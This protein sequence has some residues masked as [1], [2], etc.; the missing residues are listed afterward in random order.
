[1]LRRQG[2]ESRTRGDARQIVYVGDE[3]RA[4]AIGG[5]LSDAEIRCQ[6]SGSAALDQ[7]ETDDVDCVVAE[8]DLQ[9]VDGSQLLTAVAELSPDTARVLLAESVDDAPPNVAVVPTRPRAEL[10]ARAARRV[11][12]ATE[13]QSLR[14]EHDRIADR[15]ETLVEGSPD[16]ILTL[17]EDSEVV[18]ANEA[19]ERVFGYAPEAVVG[20]SVQKLLDESVHDCVSE[21]VESLSEDPGH[22]QRDYVELPGRHQE[23]HQVPLAV[24]FRETER[25]G[26]H[27]FSAVVRDVS[28]RERLENRLEAEKRKTKELHEVAVML[29]ECDSVEEVCRLAVETAEQLLEFDLCAVDTVKDGELVPQAVSKG[30]PTDGYYTTTPLSAEGNLA[31][32][33]YRKGESLRTGDLHDEGV[34][35]AASGYR[36]ALTVPIADL[37]VFQAVSKESGAFEESDRE[38]AE[39]LASHVAQ[40]LQRMRSEAALEAE[41]DRFAALFENI[42]EPTIDYGMHDGRPVVHSVNEAFEEVFGYDAGEAVGRTIGELIVPDEKQSEYEDHIDRMRGQDHLNT[43]VRRGGTDGI[44]DFLLRTAKI[45]DE[46][47]GGYAI[48]TDITDRKQLERDLTR[49]KQKIEELHHVAVN[50]EG[51]DTPD[52][53]YRRTV[54]AAEE[55]LKFDICGIDIEEDGY[56]VPK[57]ASS[58]LDETGYDVL[59]ADEGLAGETYQTGKSFVVDDV[60][61]VSDVE[62]VSNRYRSLLSVPFGDEGVLQAGAHTPDEFDREDRKLAELLVSHAAEALVRVQSEEAL[63]EERDRFAALFENTRD[64]V[65]YHDMCDGEPVIRSVNEAFEEVFGYDAESVLG[66]SLLDCIVPDDSIEEAKRHVEQMRQGEHVDA[67]VRRETETGTRDFLVRTASV[68]GDDTGGYVIYTDITDRKQLERDLGRANQKFEELH[69]VA[70]NLEGLN[71]AEEIYEET[72]EAA[73]EIL[74]FDICGVAIEED[75][76][77]VPRATTSDY[78]EENYEVLR[79]D[80]GIAG[81]TYQSGQS[82]VIEDLHRSPEA[83][84]VN[85]TVRSCLSVPVGEEGVLQAGSRTVDEFDQEDAKLAELLV[86][87]AS[88]ALQRLQSEAALREERD[89]FAALF[90]NVPEP[91]A[92]YELRDGDP[93][94]DSV[95]EAFEETFGYSET[96]AVGE[97]ID[98]LLVPDDRQAQAGRL[99]ERVDSG[100]R[101]DAEVKRVAD[102]GVRDFLLRNA[103]VSGD[104]GNYVIYTDVTERKQREE[105][106]DALHHATRDLMAAERQR[107]IC[108]TAVETARD[109]LDIPHSSVFK[110]D[111]ETERLEPYIVPDATIATMG[112]APSFG[113]GEGIVGSVFEDGEVAH[114]DNAWDDARALDDGSEGIRAFGAFPLGDWGVMTVASAS[115]GAFDGYEIDLVR[116]LAA[117]VEVALN[118]AA[119]EAELAEQRSQLAELDR[120]NAVIRDVD[121]LLVRS[122]T[123]EEIAQEV[124]DRLAKSDHYQFAWTGDTMAGSNKTEPTAWAGVEEGYLERIVEM[125]DETPTGPSQK[126]VETGTVQ[127]VQSVPDDE[128]F[129]PWR[130][131]A[132]KRGYQSA[133]A[134]PLRYR[135]T[136][137]GVLCVYA[138]RA[139]AFDDREQAV[140]AELGETIGHAINAAENKKALLSD[141][142]VEVEFEIREGEGFFARIP[143]EEGGTF[144]LEGVTMTAEGSFVTFMTVDGLDPDRVLELADDAPDVEQ[145]RLVNEHE[146][147]DLFEFVYTGPSPLQGLADHG[148]TLRYAKYT[149]ERG[150]TI[151]ELPRNADVRPVVESIQEELPEAKVVAQ[152]E[153][154][155]PARTVEEFRTALEEDLTERQRSALDAAYYAGFFEWPR[156]STGEEVSDSLGVSAPTFHQHLRVGERKLLSA[157][158]DE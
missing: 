142:V 85:E 13:L 48:Y 12:R 60:Y 118:R 65:V 30:V 72:V 79:T 40:S 63:R 100:E 16:P 37:G 23:G 76:R 27:Y 25:D 67:E 103:E 108:E 119:R 95:N 114:F 32:R 91:T 17:D 82:Y 115:V 143:R 154:E 83:N 6:N 36:A 39:L 33:A 94:I 152:R 18:F 90:E 86:S 8:A 38:L 19:I 109:V 126:A 54:N 137:Y 127:V 131:E 50:L 147:G 28:E 138:A 35:P 141:G 43:E 124:C 58:E 21:T 135:E 148:G 29:E 42:P 80:E 11:E 9:D 96:E 3:T 73:E 31:A 74:Q 136:V 102:D 116:V 130:E 4:E 68:P 26:K 156:E 144:T 24:S 150:R 92:R 125:R 157:F 84:I 123:R 61:E 155:R 46:G 113:S 145:A 52:E 77:L 64:A 133:A 34:D 112:E 140:L 59:R 158:L 134:I 22:V 41:R 121:Q 49:E 71:T 69:H 149:A 139:N 10:P 120:I 87:H 53:I 105:M 44:R 55:I 81:K 1:M 98:D 78:D 88:E 128:E 110:W 20:E 122:S 132:L 14:S 107:D 62:I 56:L 15:F 47:E 70:V 51:C 151:V 93:L 104:D 2:E 5:E 97:S 129:E 75:D 146:D 117:N 99:N 106:L 101:V 153:R 89:R 7:I 66:G 45:P 111:E 57:A